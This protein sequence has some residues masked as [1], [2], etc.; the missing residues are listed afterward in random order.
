MEYPCC[1]EVQLEKEVSS[2]DMPDTHQLE[3]ENENKT[4][5]DTD[6]RQNLK[7]KNETE[8]QEYGIWLCDNSLKSKDWFLPRKRYPRIHSF[9]SRFE[10]G[11]KI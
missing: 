3:P 6:F 11:K 7:C 10:C 9:M 5:E 4:T 2:K 8:Y 1:R